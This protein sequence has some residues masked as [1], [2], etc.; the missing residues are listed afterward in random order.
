MQW[1]KPATVKALRGFLGLT[2]YY[3]KFIKGYGSIAGPLTQLLQKNSFEWIDS[4][5]QAFNSLK[6]A[7]TT[8]SVLVLPDFTKPFVVECDALG[9][10]IG[11]VLM[12]DSKPITFFSQAI[13]G[14]SFYLRKRNDGSHCSGSKMAAL[15]IGTMFY[16]PN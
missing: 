7:M 4:T 3:R 16:H 10:G 13:K 9:A 6:R 14:I 15:L 2:G 1:P 5:D 11:A 8:G 12:Q